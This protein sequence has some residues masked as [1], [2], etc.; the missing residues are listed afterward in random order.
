V[1]KLT[2]ELH[3]AIVNFQIDPHKPRKCLRSRMPP[4]AW[5]MWSS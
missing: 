4:S 2:R 5:G 1:G 3:S